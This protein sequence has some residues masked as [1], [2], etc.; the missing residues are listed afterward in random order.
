MSAQVPGTVSVA[1]FASVMS[2][3]AGARRTAFTLEPP[4]EKTTQKQMLQLLDQSDVLTGVSVKDLAPHFAM[5]QSRLTVEEAALAQRLWFLYATT[6]GITR[7][8]K[9]VCAAQGD[10]RCAY[11]TPMAIVYACVPHAVQDPHERERARL[12]LAA[13]AL[14]TTTE[15]HICIPELCPDRASVANHAHPMIRITNMHICQS[16]HVYHWCN[17]ECAVPRVNNAEHQQCCPISKRQFES[18]QVVEFAERQAMSVISQSGAARASGESG[19]GGARGKGSK[20][21]GSDRSRSATPAGSRSRSATPAGSRS[22][23]GTPGPKGL[24]D[25]PPPGCWRPIGHRLGAMRRLEALAAGPDLSAL[26]PANALPLGRLTTSRRYRNLLLLF[27][28]ERFYTEA[29]F[30]AVHLLLTSVFFSKTRRTLE[31]RRIAE[32]KAKADSAVRAHL[33]HCAHTGTAV[34]PDAVK[35]IRLR[36]R[37]AATENYL[38][39]LRRFSARAWERWTVYMTCRIL[40]WRMGMLL[41][42][43][44]H[45]VQHTTFYCPIQAALIYIGAS[46]KTQTISAEARAQSGESVLVPG[47]RQMLLLQYDNS[48]GW[49]L[50]HCIPSFAFTPSH[51]T[52]GEQTVRELAFTKEFNPRMVTTYNVSSVRVLSSRQDQTEDEIRA[53]YDQARLAQLPLRR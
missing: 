43:I 14:S 36:Y 7:S 26:A 49:V 5:M 21:S 53:H 47:C 19:R 16:G 32:A 48:V 27:E 30:R 31:E 33:N 6:F 23:S 41:G 12:A 34:T 1:A 17:R 20:G 50:S 18:E 45:S 22:R 40:D 9:H 8:G 13:G 46:I 4:F 29:D 25:V 52:H 3:T 35:G 24:A 11:V 44:H 38:A 37:R 39:H 51:I 15:S 10:G 2:S 42:A 28:Q